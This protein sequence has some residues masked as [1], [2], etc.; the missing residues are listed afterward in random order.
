MLTLKESYRDHIL[1]LVKL[2]KQPKTTAVASNE[3]VDVKTSLPTTNMLTYLSDLKM[4]IGNEGKERKSKKDT[5]INTRYRL[6][7]ANK[8]DLSQDCPVI[9]DS[10]FDMAH[11]LD[12]VTRDNTFRDLFNEVATLN[13]SLSRL[14][15]FYESDGDFMIQEYENSDYRIS[16]STFDSMRQK[17]Q[18]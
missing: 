7:E 12:P 17:V 4:S 13:E 16:R 8:S 6:L 11:F 10:R 18:K 1:S 9:V 5:D 14:K 3:S 15:E 2:S